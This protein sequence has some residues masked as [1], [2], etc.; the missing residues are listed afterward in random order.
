MPTVLVVEDDEAARTLTAARLKPYYE[1]RTAH[2]GQDA[3]RILERHHVDIA[4]VDAMMP[5]MNGFELV[6]ALRA[7]NMNL[8]VLM[9]TALDSFSAMRDGFALGV[10]DYLTK[11]FNH[12]ELLWRIKALLRRAAIVDSNRLCVADLILDKASYTYTWNNVT[13]DMPK[14]EFDLL[15]LL[16]S[17]PSVVFTKNQLL[18]RVWGLHSD[19]DEAT[20]KTHISRIRARLASCGCTSIEIVNIRGLGYRADAAKGAA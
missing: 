4:V 20:L 19:V 11:P 3:L 14:K 8:P 17:Y 1:V 7:V 5:N 6:E 10:D 16:L 18:E 13:Y 12:E 9:L 2:D 15:F